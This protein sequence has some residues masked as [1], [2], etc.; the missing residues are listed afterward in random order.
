MTEGNAHIRAARPNIEIN[1]TENAALAQGLLAL[2]IVEN[3]NGLYRCEALFGNWGSKDSAIDFLY[4]DRSMLDFGKGFKVSI[5]SH[6]DDVIF[7][8][9]IMALEANFPPGRA[10][11]LRVLAEDRFQDLRMTRRTRTFND[12]TDADVVN[13][14][15]GEHGLTADV[16]IAGPAHKVLA[17][18]NQSNLA[19]LRER[20]RAIDAE[21]WMGGSKLIARSH[22]KRAGGRN[23]PALRYRQ[24]LREFTV[25]ADLSNQRTAVCVSG[26]DVAGKQGIK[27]EATDRVL[28][29]E[30]NGDLSG[31][32]ILTTALGER[33][34][35]LAH[36]VPMTSAEA[37]A[38]AEAYFRMQARRFV[39]GRGIAE[40]SG[41]WHVG[42]AVDL[43]SLGPLFSGRYCM[44]E[45]RH[46]FD[47]A[48][49]LRTEF[50]A[51]RAGL[52]RP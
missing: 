4:F 13:R 51:E 33:K 41:Q 42:A 29:G 28:G 16:D 32:S 10:P 11:E 24:D 7:D 20:A 52:G 37:Q 39:V 38:E 46:V 49:G 25:M 18:V 19:F 8:G 21:V 47:G 5:G 48:H 9:R 17:Q 30:L 50:T 36:T 34:E 44:T 26:W 2:C 45:V 14:V 12:V 15:A 1:G 35:S 40:P 3:T 27:H 22:S 23:A 43:Q 6:A 31:A